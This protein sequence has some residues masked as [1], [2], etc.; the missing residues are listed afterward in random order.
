M[1][2]N[3]HTD[4]FGV[5]RVIE[6]KVSLP[7]P[8]WKLDNTMVLGSNELLVDVK[9]LNINRVSF[10]EILESADYR[11]ERIKTRILDI[12]EER[13]KLHNPVTGT[14]GMLYGRV[15]AMG[16]N[17]PNKY[18]IKVNDEIIS[19]A[20]LSL[21]P[22]RVD[23]IL[24]I[25]YETAQLE[26]EGKCILFANSPVTKKPEDIPLKLAVYALDEA[27]APCRTYKIVKQNQHVLI[28]GA[29]GK[30]GL[31]CTYAAKDKLAGT[32]RITGL[33]K[34][35]ESKKQL[36]R[37]GAFDEVIVMDAA[38]LKD[39]YG[40]DND[41][42]EKYDIVIDCVNSL[43]TEMASLLAVKNKGII[44]F[45]SLSSDY[46]MTSLTAEGI[47]KEVEIIPYTGYLE[48]HADYSLNMIRHYEDLFELLRF[49]CEKE[50]RHGD[51]HYKHSVKK[52]IEGSALTE[53][54]IYAGEESGRVLQKALRVSEYNSNVLIYGESGVGKEIIAK[55]I[56]QNSTRKSFP[57]IKINCASIPENLLE[58]ELFGYE[59]GSFTGASTSGKIGLWE[60]AQ[61][62]TLFL[63]EVAELSMNFQAKL[64]RAIQEK[65]IIRVGGISPIKVD[66]RIIAATNKN[67]ESL[68]RQGLFREDLYYRLN[69]FPI[70]ISPLRQRKED[71]I[72]LVRWFIARYNKEFCTLKR[73]TRQAEVQLSSYPFMGNVRELQNLIQ[74]LIINSEKDIIGV[75]DVIAA[76]SFEICKENTLPVSMPDSGRRQDIDPAALQSRSSLKDMIKE[77]EEAVFR[78]YKRKY[79]STRR[80]AKV[81]GISQSS[82]ARKLKQYGLNSSESFLD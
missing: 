51:I 41:N 25:N 2:K 71:I 49:R 29:N 34:S 76:T 19:L 58:S 48:G 8:A 74:R 20:S 56:H 55:I 32:G 75:K 33:V 80:I 30:I 72:P 7:Q 40:R 6:P 5:S 17:Y 61:N 62:G 22:I 47:G 36:E 77:T 68:M 50:H 38:N 13:G 43:N 11:E 65:E 15:L 54:Y 64:L 9:I 63:D 78:E 70:T 31:L 82:V 44:F 39:F 24:S 28:I 52:S 23:E 3:V 60:A 26:V 27:G 4:E 79:G 46:K 53:K 67:L 14:G 16:E 12:I 35:K 73:I 57:I 69:V 59:K 66:V 45:A 42:I 10:N 1:V 81:L 37:Y 21:T 18:N